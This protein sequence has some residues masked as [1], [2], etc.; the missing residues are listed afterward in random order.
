MKRHFLTSIV[1]V[2][3][4][5]LGTYAHFYMTWHKD[6]TL[7]KPVR[8]EIAKGSSL[9]TVTQLLEQ[10]G[11]IHSPLYFKLYMKWHNL[12][13]KLTAGL[14][15]FRDEVSIEEIAQILTSSE[16]GNLHIT[17]PEGRNR[18]EIFK[19]LRAKMPWLNEKEWNRISE[20][21]K[22]LSELG[23]QA[24]SVEGFL[25]P[26]TY[27]F[28]QGADEAAIQQIMVKQFKKVWAKLDTSSSEL[29]AS[30][31]QIG[32]M[33]MASIVEEEAGVASERPEISGVFYGRLQKGIPLGADPTV[34]YIYRNTDGPILRSQLQ[35]DS[36]Y[37]TR[38]FKGLP[39]GPISNPGLASIK[40]ALKP[41]QTGM[42][43][44]VA[45]DDGSRE[46]YFAKTY[47]EHLKYCEIAGKNRK[48]A[49][50]SEAAE[51]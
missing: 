4:L 46:H 18:W 24:S 42:V 8:I 7:D 33:T 12:A 41:N 9:G 3:V 32:V 37:N 34:R 40:A 36:P 47:Q 1:I 2:G 14:F 39:P 30:K 29:F 35:S 13:P 17:I 20:D 15:F 5:L 51:Y 10:K 19:I 43:F 23:I 25:F 44:F 27:D 26:A 21:P 31:G 50:R 22:W 49:G 11:A 38:R 48:N 6:Y 28:P 16:K 45:K